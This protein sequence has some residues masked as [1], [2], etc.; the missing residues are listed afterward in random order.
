MATKLLL[1]S[2]GIALVY[3]VKKKR[4]VPAA[5]AGLAVAGLWLSESIFAPSPSPDRA[6]LDA[7][8][9]QSYPALRVVD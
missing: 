8:N 3:A 2:Q 5:V 6:S 4:L 1:V 7:A 9:M